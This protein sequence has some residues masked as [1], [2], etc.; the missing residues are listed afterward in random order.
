M[1]STSS[2]LVDCLTGEEVLYTLH[3][4]VIMCLGGSRKSLVLKLGVVGL[5]YLLV[6][7]HLILVW[8]GSVIFK[9]FRISFLGRLINVKN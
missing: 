5:V 3:E 8:V 6:F 2:K 7:K 9:G 1:R 4:A